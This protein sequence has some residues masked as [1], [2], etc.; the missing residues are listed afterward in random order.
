MF[1][2]IVYGLLLEIL[3]VLVI[4][5]C[6]QGEVVGMGCVGYFGFGYQVDYI[7][8]WL[9]FIGVDEVKSLIVEYM[10]YVRVY[11]SIECV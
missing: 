5:V 3:C 2:G 9:K 6:G 1:D 10:W 11:E 7:E 8:F 4:Y